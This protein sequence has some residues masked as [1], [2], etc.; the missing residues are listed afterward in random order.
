MGGDAF[1]QFPHTNT[2][3]NEISN[4]RGDGLNQ[5]KFEQEDNIHNHF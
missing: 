3:T 2:N 1:I 4:V 5:A